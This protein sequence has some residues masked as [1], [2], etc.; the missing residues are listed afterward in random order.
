MALLILRYRR[1]VQAI[2]Y[3]FEDGLSLPLFFNILDA[4]VLQHLYF[5]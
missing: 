3:Y 4:F 2:S 5:A 1:E